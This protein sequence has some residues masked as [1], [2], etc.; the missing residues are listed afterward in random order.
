MFFSALEP[1]NLD[2]RKMRAGV[3]TSHKIRE[4]SY[5]FKKLSHTE[6]ELS[7]FQQI[8]HQHRVFHP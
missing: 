6:K 1:I 8:F 2:L 7:S 3:I 4:F 5:L